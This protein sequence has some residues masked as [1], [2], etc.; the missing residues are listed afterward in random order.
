MSKYLAI[1][2]QLEKMAAAFAD[3]YAL[4]MMKTEK[5][6][7]PTSIRNGIELA[8]YAGAIVAATLAEVDPEAAHRLFNWWADDHAGQDDAEIQARAL[9]EVLKG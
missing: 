5:H 2:E 1:S 6:A 4:E 9:A 3:S 7:T 8:W